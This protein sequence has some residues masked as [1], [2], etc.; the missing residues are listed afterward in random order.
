MK[1]RRKLCAATSIL[2]ISLFAFP[3]WANIDTA[4]AVHASS[5][6]V[7]EMCDELDN[8]IAKAEELLSSESAAHDEAARATLSDALESA[9]Q[10]KTEAC[11]MLS[12]ALE[13]LSSENTSYENLAPNI[14]HLIAPSDEFI[15]ERIKDI[16]GVD[17]ILSVTKETDFNGLLN[18]PGG[19]TAQIFFSYS[20]NEDT[21]NCYETIGDGTDS[22]GSIEVYRT[23][24]DAEKRNDYLAMADG[25][26]L[27]SGSH[28]VIGTV[29]VRVSCLLPDDQQEMLEKALIDALLA[30]NGV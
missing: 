21:K 12:D 24:G 7:V 13:L 6:D 4:Y 23:V 3:L 11:S 26:I 17:N 1:F 8:A 5:Q 14:Q 22:G 18:A 29:V 15:I 19:Y 2:A 10:T 27:D 25:T 20:L 28:N 30:A 16:D 9:K